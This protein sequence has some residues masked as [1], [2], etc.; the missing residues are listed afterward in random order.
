MNNTFDQKQI[1]IHYIY[2]NIKGLSFENLLW[3]KDLV[4]EN[5]ESHEL[6]Y[7]VLI[8]RDSRVES[9]IFRTHTNSDGTPD[10]KVIEE[11]K[12]ILRTQDL[13]KYSFSFV[14]SQGITEIET[15]YIYSKTTLKSRL[16]EIFKKEGVSLIPPTKNID[17][18]IKILKTWLTSISD[19]SNWLKGDDSTL[20]HYNTK[21]LWLN[22]KDLESF[23]FLTSNSISDIVKDYFLKNKEED[24]IDQLIYLDPNEE[25]LLPIWWV[26]DILAW[27][28][29]FL[30]LDYKPELFHDFFLLEDS[31]R[32]IKNELCSL[33]NIPR[34]F[35]RVGD[36]LYS[37][38]T[39]DQIL[40]T[41]EYIYEEYV[42]LKED[43]K[44]S[45]FNYKDSSLD[46]TFTSNNIK[47]E[48][49]ILLF[50]E[51]EE[52][53]EDDIIEDTNLHEVVDI[54]EN[55]IQTTSQMKLDQLRDEIKL[56]QY[57]Q[58]EE[59]LAN[60]ISN[61]LLET[62]YPIEILNDVITIVNNRIQYQERKELKDKLFMKLMSNKKKE[63]E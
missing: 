27:F 61:M 45:M 14:N 5:K 34:L 6:I 11:Y 10:F 52:D 53:D 54:E 13:K 4:T 39:V 33:L 12:F 43:I 37:K 31:E 24:Y 56:K 46:S 17:K 47:A 44:K 22:T 28:F 51:F 35:P 49:K 59:M 8:Q 36:K 20:V 21:L 2:N 25:I 9:S 19:T 1:Y 48:E 29:Q 38:Y 32:S 58:G 57:T 7:Y 3:Y 30:H 50:N 63:V 42:P 26:R 62:N 16:Y 41:L 23:W 40:I 55:K 15:D 18:K 60:I